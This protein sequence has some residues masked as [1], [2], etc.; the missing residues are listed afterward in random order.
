MLHAVCVYS[1]INL[2]VFLQLGVSRRSRSRRAPRVF[3]GP[4]LGE[5]AGP[6]MRAYQDDGWSDRAVFSPDKV[7]PHS[8]PAVLIIETFPP[9]VFEFYLYSARIQLLKVQKLLQC[10]KAAD[11]VTARAKIQIWCWALATQAKSFLGRPWEW[12]RLRSATGQQ[13]RK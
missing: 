5:T 7:P 9:H 6:K 11:F 3:G 12:R 8:K 2:V 13:E 10:S 4:Y 1:I